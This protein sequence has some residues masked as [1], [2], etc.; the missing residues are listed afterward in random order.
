MF[1]LRFSSDEDFFVVSYLWYSA[2]FHF[3]VS[4]LLPVCSPV[5]SRNPIQVFETYHRGAFETYD[6]G[7]CSVER[8]NLNFVNPLT[9][10][11]LSPCGHDA[12]LCKQDTIH[13]ALIT[14]NVTCVTQCEGTT[15]LLVWTEF[16]SLLFSVLLYWLQP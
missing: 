5:Y 12:V 14:C 2:L 8:S 9:F 3:S 11:E 16:K 6:G 10:C 15:L 4:F 7:V 1:Y 13:R